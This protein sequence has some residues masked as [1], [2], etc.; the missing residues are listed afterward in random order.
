MAFKRPPFFSGPAPALDSLA[1]RLAGAAEATRQVCAGRSLPDALMATC[2]TLKADNSSRAAIQDIAYHTMRRLG[3]ARFM[4]NAL[5]KRSIEPDI[6]RYLLF[7]ALGLL[8]PDGSTPRYSPFTIVNQAVAAT[9]TIRHAQRAKGLVNAVL[10]N[11]LRNQQT[12]VEKAAV[13]DEARWNYPQWWID[14]VKAHYPDQ[15]QPI[16]ETGNQT[17]PLTLRVNA[18]RL[19]PEDYLK[20]L[21]QEQIDA[22]IIGPYAVRLAS[23]IPVNRIPGF[24]EGLVSVQDMAAQLATP[25]LGLK[26]GLQVLDACA[27]PGGKSA[28]MLELADISLTAL[29]SGEKRLTMIHEN[30]DRLGLSAKVIHGDATQSDWWDGTL[31]DCILADVPCSASGVIRRHPDIRWLR[32]PED[33]QQLAAYAKT[34]LDNLWVKLK[35]GGKLLF[36]TCSIW[37]E[38]SEE[39]AVFFAFKPDAQRLDASGQLLPSF[40]GLNDHDG[41]FYALFR[42][43]I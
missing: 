28:H 1:F 20:R 17:P 10:R 13:N 7:C 36:A 6:V 14:R 22:D 40:N 23:P 38:E 12:L 42:K 3:I 4:A 15:W 43:S 19:S 9:G 18:R 8:I 39:Q 16:L 30:L 31:Y 25:L 41:L 21:Q 11:Y 5:V 26:D 33:A 34:I 27:A 32:K 29:D 35:P 2:Q 37:P 24:Q